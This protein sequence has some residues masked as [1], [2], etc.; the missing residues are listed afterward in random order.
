MYVNNG[1]SNHLIVDIFWGGGGCFV[2]FF[3]N[4]VQDGGT[5]RAPVFDRHQFFGTSEHYRKACGSL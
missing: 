3:V 1:V 4:T 5:V 2:L